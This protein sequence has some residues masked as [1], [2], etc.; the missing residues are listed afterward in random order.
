VHRQRHQYPDHRSRR[1]NTAFRR[2]QPFIQFLLSAAIYS[3]SSENV[4]GMAHEGNTALK[5][6]RFSE[7]KHHKA[8]IEVL[9]RSTRGCPGKP[10]M[11]G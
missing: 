2:L 8:V 10:R 1:R 4:I 9:G 5:A 11:H 6:L 3:G 7:G